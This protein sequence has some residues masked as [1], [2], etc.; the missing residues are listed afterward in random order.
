MS[1]KPIAVL[2][3][4]SWGT[5]LAIHLARIN[6]HVRLWSHDAMQVSA[7]E[8]TRCNSRYLPNIL[9]PEN[10][11]LSDSLEK[12]LEDVRDILVVVPS[13]AFRDV[14]NQIKPHVDANTRVAWATKGLDPKQHELLH[15]VAHEILGKLPFA[16]LSGPSFAKEVA[17]ELPT[18]VTIASSSQDFA[19]ELLS[20]FHSKTF[21][22]YT[23][24]DVIG[25]ELG[26]AMKNVLAVAVG[27]ADGLGF[28]AN[29]RAA[30]ITRGLA[31]MT[32]LG[33]ALGGYQATFMGLAGVGDLILT[34]TDNQ[35]RNR[36]FGIAL[37]AGKSKEVAEKEI[38][39]VV[40][41]VRTAAEIYHLARQ[42][43]IEVPICE[44][45][46]QVLYSGL[47]PKEAVTLLLS[48][49]PKAEGI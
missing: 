26:G 28:G 10:L 9:L 31:E 37:G 29:T 47:S 13:H 43:G 17:L 21:R 48:R 46:Y 5:A 7:M 30:L 35:S 40:E 38:G 8:A 49:E 11:Q 34:C 44:R 36:R 3:A 23:S 42:A 15:T 45:A 18:A 41:G 32:R 16:V 19:T 33:L 24:T 12:T 22:V 20:L 25:V 6:S 39:Q 14:L 1:S 2:G 27:I 4:G